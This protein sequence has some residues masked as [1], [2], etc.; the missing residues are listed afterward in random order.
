M[1]IKSNLSPQP[2]RQQS[3]TIDWFNFLLNIDCGAIACRNETDEP[4]AITTTSIQECRVI[5]GEIVSHT[6][7]KEVL[8]KRL[9][10]SVGLALAGN[11]SVS[12]GILPWLS[13]AAHGQAVLLETNPAPA[14][15]TFDIPTAVA[16]PA[17]PEPVE[18]PYVAAPEPYVAPAAPYTAQP[19]PVY[20]SYTAEPEPYVAPPEPYVEAVPPTIA[21][22]AFE[23]PA[24]PITASGSPSGGCAALLDPTIASGDGCGPALQEFAPSP[25]IASPFTPAPLANSD[26]DGASP[27]PAEP[28]VS[29]S[30]YAPA[31]QVRPTIATGIPPARRLTR[32]T[33]PVQ[34]EPVQATA[35][36]IPQPPVSY[37]AAAPR[38]TAAV[39]PPP[40][41]HSALAS[42]R[43]FTVVQ[44]RRYALKP[45]DRNPLPWITGDRP[46]LF[47]LPVPVAVSSA[48]GWRQ[49]PIFKNWHIHSGID[50]AAEQGTPVLAAYDGQVKLADYIGGYGLSVL[51]S[52]QQGEQQTRYAHLSEIYVQP[53]QTVAQ[54]DVIG[55]VGSTGNSTGPHLHFETLV[56]TESGLVVT[57]PT[58]TVRES[59]IAALERQN[60][61]TK[62][63]VAIATVRQQQALSATFPDVSRYQANSILS[64]PYFSE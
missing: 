28:L 50:F 62:S 21:P 32:F 5:E 7:N 38:N 10:F 3:A 47:P 25:A 29:G 20:E 51:L 39:V 52:H 48:F 60:A 31:R 35:S 27:L 33:S 16:P 53:C 49:H 2:L 44:P 22:P 9:T 24:A 45:L 30:D 58:E 34:P 42:V 13:L 6:L 8:A 59:L 63:T 61:K 37:R 54:G 12:T 4:T 17:A 57:D 11:L 26:F 55:A 43:D 36:V 56:K 15:P 40:I 1:P 18:E 23:P 41:D 64:R 46:M 14:A 19:E